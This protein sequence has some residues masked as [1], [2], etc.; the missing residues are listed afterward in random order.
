AVKGAKKTSKIVAQ[1]I[2]FSIAVKVALMVL[3]LFGLIPLWA[4]VFGDVGVMLLAVLNSMRM[5]AKIK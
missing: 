2:V 5:R 3:S 1:N 4:A